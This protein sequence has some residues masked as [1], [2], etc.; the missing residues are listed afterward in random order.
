MSVGTR[1]AMSPSSRWNQLSSIRIADLLQATRHEAVSQSEGE[2]VVSYSLTLVVKSELNDE[3]PEKQ[4]NCN[5]SS[6]FLIVYFAVLLSIPSIRPF[7]GSLHDWNPLTQ[8]YNY[9]GW[10]NYR[11]VL[12]G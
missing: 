12:G 6:F 11:F 8:K 10:E 9:I 2:G 1:H 4:L 7:A 3:Y 5:V